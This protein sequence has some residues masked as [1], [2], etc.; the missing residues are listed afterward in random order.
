MYESR[1]PRN[2]DGSPHRLLGMA[3]MF[4]ILALVNAEQHGRP[5]LVHTALLFETTVVLL[6][7]RAARIPVLS[8]LPHL[9]VFG[10]FGEWEIHAKMS[11]QLL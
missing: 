5:W 4:R 6:S 1:A 10:V 2:Y 11:G 3:P 8:S 7:V 9:C